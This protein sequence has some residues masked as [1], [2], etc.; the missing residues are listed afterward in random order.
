MGVRYPDT[1]KKLSAFLIREQKRGR[2]PCRRNR[3]TTRP[4]LTAADKIFPADLPLRYGRWHNFLNLIQEISMPAQEDYRAAYRGR[5]NMEV[6]IARQLNRGVHFIKLEDGQWKCIP[7]EDD[8]SDDN[9]YT[10]SFEDPSAE[11]QVSLHSLVKS[12]GMSP[13]GASSLDRIRGYGKAPESKV[14]H[15]RFETQLAEMNAQLFTMDEDI[16]QN[17]TDQLDKVKKVIRNEED[18]ERTLNAVEKMVRK[19]LGAVSCYDGHESCWFELRQ[20]TRAETSFT[21]KTT[22]TKEE[23]GYETI[24]RGYYDEN[25]LLGQIPINEKEVFLPTRKAFEQFGVTITDK[26][27]VAP[28]DH[29]KIHADWRRARW[30]KIARLEDV[31]IEV[32]QRERYH[33][34]DDDNEPL[35]GYDPGD[36]RISGGPASNCI[37][38]WHE[39]LKVEFFGEYSTALDPFQANAYDH[40]D[41]LVRDL[42]ADGRFVTDY[43][44]IVGH[45]TTQ[46]D[47]IAKLD[48]GMILQDNDRPVLMFPRVD[49]IHGDLV[50]VND[51][52][53]RGLIKSKQV[54]VVDQF[55]TDYAY[56]AMYARPGSVLAK[57]A[58]AP[59]KPKKKR[60]RSRVVAHDDEGRAITSNDLN[61][62]SYQRPLDGMAFNLVP[63]FDFDG[64]DDDWDEQQLIEQVKERR[65]QLKVE[66]TKG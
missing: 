6:F 37:A 10:I 27:I 59:P 66:A 23:V 35:L 11:D 44:R 13:V 32:V 20:L 24:D 8:V 41:D 19:G 3:Q 30:T 2:P 36:T 65:R 25:G 5:V 48:E 49:N 40:V 7:E 15:S 4:D 62:E 42:L 53:A 14:T 60:D 50:S 9:T 31:R 54:V 21:L 47:I 51:Q 34:K 39:G 61:F 56:I 29:R 22:R 46:K 45:C 52:I 43:R 28:E 38:A 16:F 1:D 17:L 12:G 26:S 33:F 55:K 18:Q 57:N 58:P 64:T 63:S